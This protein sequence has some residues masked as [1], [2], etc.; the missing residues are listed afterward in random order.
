MMKIAIIQS[1]YI[2]WKGY[3]DMIAAVDE[4][5][6]YDDMQYTRRDWRNRNQIKT[7]QG[8]QWLTVPVKVK[9]KYHQ[10]IRETEIDG[11][12]WSEAHWKSISQNYRKAPYFEE[13]SA[14]FE[15]IYRQRQHTHLS[16]LNRELIEAVCAYL[17]ITTKISNSWDY[18]LIGGQTECLAN[19]CGQA[20]AA[21]YISG[22]SARNY[23]DE[24]IFLDRKIKLTWFE[25]D[26]YPE[27]PQLWG[28][29][30]HAVS[31]LDL[32][33]NCGDNAPHYMKYVR[34]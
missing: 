30:E 32:L 12:G 28:K 2:P 27:Y 19:L 22:P 17:S 21:E 4:F 31:I 25:Y 33:F 16:A 29:F 11:T 9:G 6:L 7:P 15:P 1:N 20:G 24:T 34:T 18:S 26:G 13:I 10:A 14:I 3:F 8:V 5:I 23:L